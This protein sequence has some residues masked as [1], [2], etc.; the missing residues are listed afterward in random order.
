M[1]FRKLLCSKFSSVLQRLINNHITMA[2]TD[3]IILFDLSSKDNATN[4]CWSLNPWK[5]RLVLNYKGLPYTTEFLDYPD[6]EKRISPHLKAEHYTSP[7]I[8]YTDGRYIMDSRVIAETLEKDHPN[9]PMHL[10]SPYLANLER[11]IQPLMK[12][13]HPHYVP[14][15]A[16]NVLIEGPSAEYFY[17]TRTATVGMPLDEYGKKKGQDFTAAEPHLKTITG[18]LK[19]NADGPYFMGKTVSYVDFQWGGLLLF[20][21]RIDSTGKTFEQ[22]LEATGDAKVHLTLLEALEPF[23]KRDDH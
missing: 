2:S 9:P 22:F 18:W 4:K 8:K 23:S 14:K 10:D 13:L 16:R 15:V 1:L 17:R 7:T 19:E 20:I 5:T 11:E 3:Q 12:A 21:R 6:I